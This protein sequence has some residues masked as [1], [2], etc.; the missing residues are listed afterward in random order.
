VWLIFYSNYI[1]QKCENCFTVD[2][3]IVIM[4]KMTPD[5]RS[6]NNSPVKH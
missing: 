4:K 5:V 3:V 1:L 2:K 6:A